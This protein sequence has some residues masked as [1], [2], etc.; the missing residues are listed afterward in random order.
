MRPVYLTG[1]MASGKS[2]V[3]PL[4]AR[5][6][7]RPYIDLDR[8]IIE[9]AGLSIPEVFAQ[10]GEQRFRELESEA[11]RETGAQEAVVALGGGAL[12]QPNNLAFAREKGVVVYL[13]AS[14][15]AILERLQQGDPD[16]PM[17]RGAD[18]RPLTRKALRDRIRT[19]LESRV[20]YYEQAHF[21]VETTG[22]S[23]AAVVDEVVRRLA[24]GL[25]QAE[26]E[27]S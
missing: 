15:D 13:D 22:K 14:V 9:K 7:G 5:R 25:P 6:L 20:P 21:R 12:A 24:L 26:A 10:F 16:R 18:G 8:I 4:L 27:P 3:G 1:F 19:L 11:L 2:S 23:V 17:L